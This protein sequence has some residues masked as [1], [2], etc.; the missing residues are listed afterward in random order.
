ML[1]PP[2]ADQPFVPAEK[3]AF[4]NNSPAEYDPRRWCAMSG[5]M[6]RPDAPSSSVISLRH[7]ARSEV[8]AFS[9]RTVQASRSPGRYTVCG[10][11]LNGPMLAS[12][13]ETNRQ[14]TDDCR[15]L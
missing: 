9:T 14:S 6:I 10:C 12:V 8:R 15:T 13:F 11:P 4:A 5:N 2:D 1:L 3:S 7:A